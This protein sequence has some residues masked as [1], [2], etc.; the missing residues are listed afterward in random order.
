MRP[1]LELAQKL[2]GKS[3]G[4]GMSGLAPLSYTTIRH[5]RKECGLPRFGERIIDALIVIDSVMLFPGEPKV[6]V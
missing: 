4:L 6:D 2:H 3:G 1:L 5:Y